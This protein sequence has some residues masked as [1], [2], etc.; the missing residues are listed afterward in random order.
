LHRSTLHQTLALVHG[1][2]A[3]ATLMGLRYY[4]PRWQ[5]VSASGMRG[6]TLFLVLLLGS[7]SAMSLLGIIDRGST[8][9]RSIALMLFNLVF[10]LPMRVVVG[11]NLNGFRHRAHPRWACMPD[12]HSARLSFSLRQATRYS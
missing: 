8:T 1:V 6:F 12:S 7:I 3:I 2:F 10:R 9:L 5:T 4:L 11:L